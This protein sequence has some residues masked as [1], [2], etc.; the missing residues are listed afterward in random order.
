V[1]PYPIPACRDTRNI[2]GLAHLGYHINS[3]RRKAKEVI[4]EEEVKE[5]I[6]M[7]LKPLQEVAKK[8]AL[9]G[10]SLLLLLQLT[11]QALPLFCLEFLRSVLLR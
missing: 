10:L 8:K 2:A 1:G 7:R 11:N 3:L 5:I 4:V 6:E 9:A